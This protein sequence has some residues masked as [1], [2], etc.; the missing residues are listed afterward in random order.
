[1][2]SATAFCAACHA[3]WDF[4]KIKIC[5]AKCLEKGCREVIKPKL[6]DTQCGFRL[7]RSTTDQIFTLHHIFE[8]S[9]EY[10]EYVFTNALSTSRKHLTG[11]LV[12]SFAERCGCTVVTAACYWPSRHCIPAQKFMSL[13][14]ELNHDYS[15]RALDSDKGVCCHHTFS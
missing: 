8:K 13:S 2:W 7:G 12:K 4:L 15:P 14:G 5:V 11:F 6:N 10:A 1:M 3:F 9:W